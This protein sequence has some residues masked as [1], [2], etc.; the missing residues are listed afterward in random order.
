MD[1]AASDAIVTAVKI[2]MEDI[3]PDVRCV[4]KYGGE[5]FC[6]NPEDDKTFFGGVFAYKD[7]VS[8]EFSDGASLQDTSG[9]LEGKGKKRRHL[10]FTEVDDVEGKNARGFLVQAVKAFRT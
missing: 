8:L 3:A 2:L 6:P 5:V 10:K 4:P 9:V 1:A 7:H